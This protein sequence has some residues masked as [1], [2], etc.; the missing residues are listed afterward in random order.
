[1]HTDLELLLLPPAVSVVTLGV[2]LHGHSRK[3]VLHGV[4]AEVITDGAELQQIPVGHR[5]EVRYFLKSL[6]SSVIIVGTDFLSVL[7]FC[8]Y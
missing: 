6:L 5:T 7:I 3:E 4:V 1:M 8:L 2:G